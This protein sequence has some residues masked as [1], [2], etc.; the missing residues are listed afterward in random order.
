MKLGVNIDHI[1]T[2]RQARMTNE[3]DPIYA[4]AIAELAGADGITIHLRQDRR[5][6][7]ERDLE[8]L[9]AVVKTK[10]NLEMAIS[11]EMVKIALKHKPDVCTLVPETADEV[12]T[13][14]GLD[15][16]MYTEKVEEVAGNLKAAGMEVSVFID[17]NID[18]IKACYKSGIKAIEINTG[19]YAKNWNNSYAQLEL[20]KIKKSATY[21]KKVNLK[22]L[23]GHGLT[24]QNIGPIAAIEEIEELNIGHT[25]I[26][27]ST[28]MGLEKAVRRMKELIA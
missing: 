27:N 26:S 9:R 17:P 8:L 13:T 5:H 24:Y 18:Q 1:A 10:L 20:D 12:T 7:Q 4:A 15:V 22:V 14:G 28:F 25:I 11:M 2:L 6:I 19:E 16:L 3:P 23:A 21:A